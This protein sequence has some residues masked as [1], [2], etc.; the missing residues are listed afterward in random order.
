MFQGLFGA[1]L[2]SHMVSPERALAGRPERPFSLPAR[3][4]VFDTPLEGPFPDSSHVVYLGLGCFWG[5]EKELWQLPGVISTAVGYMG[6]YTPHP[7]YEEVCSGMTGH[8]EVVRVVY[9]PTVISDRNILVHFWES[10]DPTQGFRQG[11]DV[12]TQYRSAVYVTTTDQER[13]ARE[14][15]MSFQRALEER[16][17]GRITTQ[18]AWAGSDHEDGVGDFYFAEDYH[19]QYLV[20]NPQGYCPVHSTGVACS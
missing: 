19:Q 9:D 18:V 10:H 16:G 3:H 4:R 6:G 7:L 2:R 8:T 20:K 17:F 5:A 13:L 12:G 14:T 1:S 11:N 15:L